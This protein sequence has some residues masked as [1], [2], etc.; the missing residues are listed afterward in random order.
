[1]LRKI[2]SIGLMALVISASGNA[3]AGSAAKELG[4]ANPAPIT[5]QESVRLDGKIVYLGDL[6][7]NVGDKAKVAVAYTPAPGKRS[8]FDARWLY[9]VARTNK[10]NWRPLSRYD[11]VVVER[12]STVINREQIAEEILM[13]LVDQ[14]V[15]PNSEVEFSNRMLRLHV[16]GSALAVVG[17]E[18]SILDPRTNRFSAIIH[19]PAGD[20]SAKRIRITGRVHQTAEVPVPV[21]RILGGE[22][23]RKEDLKWIKVRSRR[24]QNDVIVSDLDLIGKSPR[25]GL[26][27][28]DPVRTSMV[29][30]PVLVEKGS[31]VTIF[32][33]A[34]KMTLTAKG[35]AIVSGSEGDVIQV[36]NIQSK[37]VIEAEIIGSGRVAVRPITHLAMN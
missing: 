12:S 10:I 26:R 27:A 14:G 20:P 13:A 8:V 36:S 31:L 16:G 30:R 5:L 2:L 18:D 21:R 19:A 32:L 22:V 35:K 17:V 3:K 23:I 34:P 37:T 15:D 11:R 33:V 9:R 1:M 4:A 7:A 29:R 6:F 24:L 25:R 28:G